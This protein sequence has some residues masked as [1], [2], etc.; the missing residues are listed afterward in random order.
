MST[1]DHA[2]MAGSWQLVIDYSSVSSTST[3]PD[4]RRR[5][6]D[7]DIPTAMIEKRYGHLAKVTDRKEVVEFLPDLDKQLERAPA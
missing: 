5:I 3:W 1:R 2:E 6:W 7:H 4:I